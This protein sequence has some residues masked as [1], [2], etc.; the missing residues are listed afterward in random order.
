M[1]GKERFS[2]L[3]MSGTGTESTIINESCKKTNTQSELEPDKTR[4]S[5]CGLEDNE[6]LNLYFDCFGL[7]HFLSLDEF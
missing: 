6:Q 2:K 5:T 1:L 4:I 3:I 7:T